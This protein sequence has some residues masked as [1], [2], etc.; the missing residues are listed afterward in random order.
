MDSDTFPLL[1]MCVC[2]FIIIVPFSTLVIV[3]ILKGRKQAWT[4]T[5]IDKSANEKTDM[6]SDRTSVIYSV[7]IRT[8]EGKEFNYGV[9]ATKYNEYKI[10][11]RLKK[12]SGKLWA[13]KI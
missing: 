10:G 4:G 11:D 9:D 2:C 7:K 12:E 1:F 13:E 5:I 3:L 8:D 6:D